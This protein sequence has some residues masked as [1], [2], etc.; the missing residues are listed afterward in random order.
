LELRDTILIIFGNPTSGT[1]GMDSV[2]LAALH[3]ALNQA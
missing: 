2:P 3:L 1:P